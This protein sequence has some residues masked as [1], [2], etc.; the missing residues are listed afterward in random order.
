[1]CLLPPFL[2]RNATG[3]P[4]FGLAVPVDLSLP[5]PTGSFKPFVF[6]FFVLLDDL[7]GGGDVGEVMGSRYLK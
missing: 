1:M 2:F 6:P 7:V 5:H 4:V 3:R